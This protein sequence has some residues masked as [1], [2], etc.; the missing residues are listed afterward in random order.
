MSRRIHMQDQVGADKIDAIMSHYD[1]YSMDL[2]TLK[3]MVIGVF[4]LMLIV[5]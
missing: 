5:T 2:W 1:H 3:F 4:L